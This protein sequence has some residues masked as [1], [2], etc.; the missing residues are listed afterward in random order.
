MYMPPLCFFYWKALNRILRTDCKVSPSSMWEPPPPN[1]LN[2]SY[3]SNSLCLAGGFPHARRAT[4]NAHFY[5]V[6]A[7]LLIF[8]QKFRPAID[9]TPPPPV[10]PPSF[11]E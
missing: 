1:V 5:Y 4:H 7:F 9:A 2:Y 10:K 11:Y 3:I 6:C 8:T